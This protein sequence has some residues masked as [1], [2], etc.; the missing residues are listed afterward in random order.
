LIPSLRVS[1]YGARRQYITATLLAF[2]EERRCAFPKTFRRNFQKAVTNLK[3]GYDSLEQ[4]CAES[5][6]NVSGLRDAAAAMRKFFLNPPKDNIYSM[7]RGDLIYEKM[8][9]LQLLSEYV[10]YLVPPTG[11]VLNKP[12]PGDWAKIRR[13]IS[14]IS[15]GR[16]QEDIHPTDLQNE[17]NT[18][19]KEGG[20]SQAD[21]WDP[22]TGQFTDRY[23][24][25]EG[26]YAQ[27]EIRKVRFNIWTVWSQRRLEL[28]QLYGSSVHGKIS[29]II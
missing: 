18:L 13:S 17:I 15:D 22:E 5:E 27:R 20:W 14:L 8:V 1:S 26:R 11:D 9:A 23:Y 29:T 16:I 10:Q 7:Q 24:E 25:F 3:E 4:C 6:M 21:W 28:D 19:I 2:G 12:A